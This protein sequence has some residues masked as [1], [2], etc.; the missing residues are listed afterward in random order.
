MAAPEITASV[1]YFDP[2]ITKCIFLP[3]I[4]AANL[5][6]TRTE[7][8]AGTDL[9]PEIAEVNGF[10]VTSGVINTPNMGSRF[11]GTIPG[12]TNAE[13]SSITFYADQAG[14]DVRTILPRDATGYILWADGGD[15]A[16]NKGQVY[17]IRVQSLGQLRSVGDESHRLQVQFSITSEPNEDVTIPA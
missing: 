7:I 1:R 9:S 11:T 3:A 5:V 2:G 15:V 8:N 17:P 13:D 6:P 14:N 4:A 16:G 12:R 10:T